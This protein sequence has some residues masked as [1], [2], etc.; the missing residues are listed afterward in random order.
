MLNVTLASGLIEP[1]SIAN[2]LHGLDIATIPESCV[3]K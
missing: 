2:C 3:K 1:L